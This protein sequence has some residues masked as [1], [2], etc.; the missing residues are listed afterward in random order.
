MEKNIE[1]DGCVRDWIRWQFLVDWKSTHDWSF[2]ALL[3]HSFYYEM[4]LKQNNMS[5]E[6]C[7]IYHHSS[8]FIFTSMLHM[9][10]D[11]GW[12]RGNGINFSEEIF[13][14]CCCCDIWQRVKIEKRKKNHFLSSWCKCDPLTLLVYVCVCV[15]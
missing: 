3:K 14:F 2:F 9:A 8:H 6:V 5:S 10:R 4:V 15:L 1:V 7:V 11:V 13:F 12:C